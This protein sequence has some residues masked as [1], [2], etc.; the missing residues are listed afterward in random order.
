[1]EEPRVTEDNLESSPTHLP[2]QGTYWRAKT[3]ENQ[4]VHWEVPN[5]EERYSHTATT[6]QEAQ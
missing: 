3:G 6:Q 4:M 5:A 1:M 2:R